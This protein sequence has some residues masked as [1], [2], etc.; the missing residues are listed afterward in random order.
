MINVFD[1]FIRLLRPI[2]FPGKKRLLDP[3]VPKHGRLR[4][5]VFGYE[6]VLDV[7][8][9]IQ[10]CIYLGCYER[11]ETQLVRRQLKRG[12]TFLDVGANVGYFSLLA[13]S[14]VGESGRVLSIEPLPDLYQILKETIDRNHIKN[15]E[16]LRIGLDDSDHVG[17]IYR[18]PESQ[19]NNSPSVFGSEEGTPVDISFKRLDN[20]LQ[21]QNIETVDVMKVD[22]EGMEAR[23]LAGASEAMTHR[24]IKAVLMEFNDYWLRKAGTTPSSPW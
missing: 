23:T 18:P 14:I 12:M 21:E 7:G 6:T 5:N 1:T 2:Q 8:E 17:V 20:T 15:I 10:R 24:R 11:K 4:A 22:V 19:H 16:L 13:A 3:I 9:W